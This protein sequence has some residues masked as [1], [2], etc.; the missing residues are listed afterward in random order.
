MS[1]TPMS[2]F[3]YPKVPGDGPWSVVDVA[4]PTSYVQMAQGTPPTGGQ[5]LTAA[6]FGL[7]SLDWVAVIGPSDNYQYSV[8]VVPLPLLPGSP[9]EAMAVAWS[10]TATG[11]QVAN[12]INLSARTVRMLGIGR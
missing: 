3:S 6:G 1:A 12:G 10:V 9:F 2:R 5:I 4:G 7:Q 11:A 8:Q